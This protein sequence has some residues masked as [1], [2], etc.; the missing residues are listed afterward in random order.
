MR[1]FH[2]FKFHASLSHELNSHIW[3]NQEKTLI[4]TSANRLLLHL[5]LGVTVASEQ[6]LILLHDASRDITE[7]TGGKRMRTTVQSAA[8]TE[9]WE[10]FLFSLS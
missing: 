10:D 4:R 3:S 5:T 8:D 7:V 6:R 9:V 2:S 1:S